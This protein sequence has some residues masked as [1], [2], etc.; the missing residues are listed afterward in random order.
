[1]PSQTAEAVAPDEQTV[2]VR[3]QLNDWKIATYR[4]SDVEGL[5]GTASAALVD[6]AE[7]GKPADKRK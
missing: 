1:M 7:A 3:R 5:L 2:D 4:I 6:I